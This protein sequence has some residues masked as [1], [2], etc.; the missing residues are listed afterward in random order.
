MKSLLLSVIFIIT[1]TSIYSQADSTESR[2]ALSFGILSDFRLSNFDMDI[3]GKKIIDET[4][5]LRLFLSPKISTSSEDNEISE[6]TQSAERN[7]I[8][9]SLGVGAD[10]IWKLLKND[11]FNF[12]GGTG[13]EFTYG[14]SH[15]KSTNISDIGEKNFAERKAPFWF[16]GVRGVLGVEWMVSKKIGIHSEYLLVGLYNWNKSE[17]KSTMNGTSTQTVTSKMSGINLNT[18]VLFGVSIYL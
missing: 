10:Y 15:D 6:S 16:T 14:Y 9:F 17:T 7:F 3:A 5:Q 13:L 8:R 11:D 1:C 18:Q 12:Y 4:H 2:Y